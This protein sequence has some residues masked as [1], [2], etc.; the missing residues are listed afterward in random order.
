[1]E[2]HLDFIQMDAQLINNTVSKKQYCKRQDDTINRNN[3]S[4][5]NH[6]SDNI[7]DKH[8]PQPKPGLQSCKSIYQPGL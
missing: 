2:Y 8:D 3:I 7:V 5:N 4:D 1:M 6:T